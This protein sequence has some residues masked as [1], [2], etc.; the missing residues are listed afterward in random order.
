MASLK[1]IHEVDTNGPI[2]QL[3]RFNNI[4]FGYDCTQSILEIDIKH[5]LLIKNRIDYP[6]ISINCLRWEGKMQYFVTLLNQI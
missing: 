2:T 6:P 5:Q 1:L 4:V 3:S